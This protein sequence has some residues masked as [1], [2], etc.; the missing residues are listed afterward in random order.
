MFTRVPNCTGCVRFAVPYA[1]FVILASWKTV[2]GSVD[3]P[4]STSTTNVH[5]IAPP[6]N[7]DT[8][9]RISWSY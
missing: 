2:L 5:W 8:V 9:E 7:A 4:E 1:S 3:K 6:K